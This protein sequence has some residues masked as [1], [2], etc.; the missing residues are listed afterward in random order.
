MVAPEQS[1]SGRQRFPPKRLGFVEHSALHEQI[2]KRVDGRQ[3]LR[4]IVAQNAPLFLKRLAHQGFTF[5]KLSLPDEVAAKHRQRSKRVWVIFT[6][7]LTMFS[8]R[9]AHQLLGLFQ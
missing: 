6:K 1:L 7:H 3:S 5:D 9:S 4:M 2:G 8:Q